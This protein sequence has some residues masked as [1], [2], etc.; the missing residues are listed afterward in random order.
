VLLLFLSND[1]FDV[2]FVEYYM[3]MISFP[4]CK[5]NI[6]LNIVGK[7]ADGYHNIETV[8]YPLTLC[9]ALE[10]LP[11]SNKHS[12]DQFI[13]EGINFDSDTE[14]NLCM[15][16]LRLMQRAKVIP[17]VKIV[18]MKNIPVGAGLGGG[19]SDAAFTLKMI[20]TLY[21]VGFTD[22][23]LVEM[24]S[25]LGSDCAFFILNKPVFASGKG[26]QMTPVSLLLAGYTIVIVKPPVFV[27]TAEAYSGTT[28]TQ[29]DH[30][31]MDLI[32]LPVSQWRNRIKNDFEETIFPNHPEIAAIKQKLYDMGAIYASMSGSGSSLFGFFKQ[33]VQAPD[34]FPGCFY[35]EEQVL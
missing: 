10:I 29:P 13:M 12:C 14:D 21:K 2:I 35:H 7:R 4:N 23:Q 24:S 18:L 9:D 31:L 3:H 22:E 30:S 15:K 11:V 33:P 34:A 20:N 32:Q 1:F 27:S 26:D 16:A 17:L 28:P 6:G 8:F 5:I 25:I 19:S